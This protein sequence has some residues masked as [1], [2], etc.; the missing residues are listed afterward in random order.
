[1]ATKYTPDQLQPHLDYEIDMLN[2]SY[3]L[4]YQIR[5]LLDQTNAPEPQKK[6]L[7]TR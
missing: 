7:R 5:G 3:S 4:I 1:M 6:P 2:R